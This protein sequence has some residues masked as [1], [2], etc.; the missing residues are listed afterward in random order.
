MADLRCLDCGGVLEPQ[1]EGY[2]GPLIGWRCATCRRAI[3]AEPWADGA[4]L[5]D[6]EDNPPADAVCGCSCGCDVPLTKGN[7]MCPTANPG[8]EH[9]V[10][11]LICVECYTGA[12]RHHAGAR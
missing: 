12:H 5:S 11:V 10:K 1:C 6:V 3:T 2:D 7:A 9:V 4:T 8:E